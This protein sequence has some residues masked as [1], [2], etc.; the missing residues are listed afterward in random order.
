[1][2]TYTFAPPDDAIVRGMPSRR[3][4]LLLDGLPIGEIEIHAH[5][6]R[7]RDATPDLSWGITAITYGPLPPADTRPR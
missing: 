3:Q 1:M 7:G 6:R 4:L 5:R 2:D